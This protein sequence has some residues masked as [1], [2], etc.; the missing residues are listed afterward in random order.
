MHGARLVSAVAVCVAGL[1]PVCAQPAGPGNALL[2]IA[3]QEGRAHSKPRL[4]Q[5]IDIGTYVASYGL[6]YT[7]SLSKDRKTCSSHHWAWT[8]HMITLGMPAPIRA[9]WYSTGFVAIRLDGMSLHDLPTRFRAVRTGGPDAMAQAVWH[10]PKGTL[11]LRLLMRSG[12]DK[13]LMQ[14]VLGPDVKVKRFDLDL[15]CYPQGFDKPHNRRATTA[16]RDVP[17][18]TTLK[19][20]PAKEPWAFYYDATQGVPR[21][22]GPVGMVYVPAETARVEVSVASYEN[23]TRLTAKP[24]AR[25]LTVG[26]WDFS[27]LRDVEA[28]KQYLREGGAMIAADLAAVAR[29][30]WTK[31]VTVPVRL[32]QARI[33]V[34][35]DLLR[36]RMQG[37]PFDNMTDQ[38]VTPHIAWAKP[39]DRGPVRTLVVAPRWMQRETVELA[40]RLDM[41]Y[42]TVGFCQP[43][44]IVRGGDLY[45]YHNYD[46]YGYPRA[47]AGIVLRRL[48]RKLDATHD[49]LILSSFKPT[50]LPEA[51]RKR[52][53]GKVHAGTGLVLLG[54]AKGLLA[55]FGKDARPSPCRLDGV[56]VETLPGLDKMVRDKK[57]IWNTYTY[58]QGRVLVFN[59]TTGG[60]WKR[61]CLT[62]RLTEKDPDVLHF[63]DYYYSLVAKAV[64]WAARRELPVRIRWPNRPG[65]CVI[66]SDRPV[67]NAELEV[68]YD[69]APR[70]WRRR[71]RATVNL[72][73]GT[74]EYAL[75]S[76]ALP[77]GQYY[78]SVWVRKGGRVLGWATTYVDASKCK[79]PRITALEIAETMLS[80]GQPVRGTVRLSQPIAGA[81][82]DLEVWDS[83]DRL[84]RRCRLPATRTAVPFQF[85]LGRPCAIVHEVRARL[86][87][88]RQPVD[89]R[90]AEFTVVDRRVDDFHFLVWHDGANDPVAHGISRVLAECGVDWLDNVYLC[91][92][93]PERV[94]HYV[95]NAAR[96]GLAS[97]PY[98]ARIASNQTSG[99][100]RQPCLTDPKH[101]KRWTDR[102]REQARAAAPYGPPAYTLGDEN[103]LVHLHLDVC[104]SPSCL[105]GF[106][107]YLQ[108]QYGTIERL[109]ASWQTELKDWS[110]AMPATLKEVK[111]RPAHWPRWAD[112]RFFMTRVFTGAHV[113][114][115]E[116]IRQGDPGARVGWDGVFGL[117]GWTGYDFYHL[118]RS[119]DLNQVYVGQ[120]CQVEY[121]RSWHAPDAVLGVWHNNVGNND[122]ISAKRVAWHA[123]FH[124]L[125]S[126]WYWTSFFVGPAAL[127]PDLRP[128][129]QLEWMSTSHGEI[130]AGVGKLLLGAKRQHDG[131]AIH[132][133][134]AS[135]FAGALLH[136]SL[137]PAQWGFARVV[138]DLGLQYDMLAYEQIEQ[139]GLK[140]YKVLL[141]PAC[142]ALSPA[143]TK[144]ISEFVKQGGLVVADTVPG[145]LD[146]HCR[147]LDRGQLDDLCGANRS[148]RPA[149]AG[150]EKI[151]VHG[152]ELDIE[153]PLVAS[154]AGLKPKGAQA[155][156]SAGKTPCVLVHKAGAGHTVVLNT[157]M[158]VYEDL[159]KG[160]GG[161][162]V[163]RLMG[164]LLEL[165]GVH[166][167]VRITAG[168]ADVDACET[169]RFAHGGIH[170]VGIVR[171][172]DVIGARTQDVTIGLPRD[173]CVY[174]VR[175]RQSIGRCRTLETTL[176]PGD[177]KLYA[178]LPYTVRSVTAKPSPASVKAGATI[179]LEVTLD[180][181]TGTL[182]GSHCLRVELIGPNGKPVAHYAQNVLTDK[183]VTTVAVELAVNDPPGRWQVGVRDVATGQSAAVPL[184]VTASGPPLPPHD[185]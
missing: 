184:T 41:R 37:T 14:A 177:P 94:R 106:R 130:M 58:G 123:L 68:M 29:A 82:L 91:G 67:P 19:L 77:V 9:N 170:Y 99:R 140:D 12:D 35:D 51:M 139:G 49:C 95:R 179:A 85:A 154:D 174:D 44:A 110:E 60:S 10:T 127:F 83:R 39:L 61:T 6:D 34:Y 7:V 175:A 22:G 92:A 185:K 27:F 153:L 134:Q 158:E 38:V 80:P 156:A 125:N 109:N 141:M 52:I 176:V 126:G 133:S 149:G 105:A 180:T 55:D 159:R 146:N 79:F 15:L 93:P 165:A 112:H 4:S 57:P 122:A 70:A 113:K 84:V 145:I 131:I 64:L 162:P 143:E 87:Q 54:E 81:T 78:Q 42:E 178:L 33:K 88:G 157:R 164:R 17:S 1:T 69:E 63:H 45:C 31:P 182:A 124:G 142:S 152:G 148:G 23:R 73:K 108:E 30:D 76:A 163:R 11:T 50:L 43:D 36:R 46:L 20:D 89:Q 74:I 66:E 129:P 118:C 120:P 161:Q 135:V 5:Q 97:I 104:T 18:S 114:G 53:V 173:A 16:T 111:S 107:R 72:P 48:Q 24:G 168:G 172:D 47:G 2:R 65:P 171:D 101:L 75:P 132:Y 160:G 71:R 21:G 117:S 167:Q 166:T 86:S 13:L 103:Y 8:I 56:P 62:P 59:Y 183:P 98:V 128:T 116:A 137:T 40:Q 150:K 3:T 169:V 32:P 151:R 181:S 136:R 26:L 100:V 90:V 25:K 115:R 102:L 155:W 144:A 121:I 96:H 28:N 138:E 119:C 147:L